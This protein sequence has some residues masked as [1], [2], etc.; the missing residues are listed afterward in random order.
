MLGG[1]ELRQ[2]S[3]MLASSVRTTSTLVQSEKAGRAL[4]LNWET[5]VLGENATVAA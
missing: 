3:A 5:R 1:S 2:A 4:K